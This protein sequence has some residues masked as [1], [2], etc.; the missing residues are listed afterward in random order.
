MNEMQKQYETI[1]QLLRK[2]YTV[3]H[4]HRAVRMRKEFQDLWVILLPP[5]NTEVHKMIKTLLEE[6]SKSLNRLTS[7]I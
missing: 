4:L 5:T 1:L 7:K 2:A 3:D 6:E